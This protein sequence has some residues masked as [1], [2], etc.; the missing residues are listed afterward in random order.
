MSLINQ[1]SPRRGNFWN[2]IIPPPQWQ[3]P[4]IILCGIIV[5]LGI[6]IMQIANATSYLSDDPKACI[7]CHIM[8][9]EYST[10][11]HSSHRER[12]N[13]NDCHVPH[14]NI[15]RKYFFKAQD[16]LRHATIFTLRK[17]PQVIHIGDAGKTVV[18]EN[19]LRCHIKQVNPISATNVNGKNFKHGEGMLCWGCHREIPHGRTHSLTSTPNAIV[20]GLSPVIPEWLTKDE[21]NKGVK[22]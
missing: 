7:N 17:E 5:G 16:G 11:Q 18:Q 9:P 10:W 8:T 19:C 22:K 12:A 13:C 3:L 4:V 14:N 6:S 20:P 1:E 2:W 15:I 21:S